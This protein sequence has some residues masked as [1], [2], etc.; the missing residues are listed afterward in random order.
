MKIGDY[1]DT[2]SMEQAGVSIPTLNKP[3][4]TVIDV[5]TTLKPSEMYVKYNGECNRR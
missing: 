3:N 4:N 2:L 5:E 1:A